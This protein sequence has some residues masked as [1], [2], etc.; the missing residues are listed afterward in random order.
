MRALVGFV[1]WTMRIVRQ[2]QS[3]SLGQYPQ[4]LDA[5][6]NSSHKTVHI[7]IRPQPLTMSAVCWRLGLH[8]SINIILVHGVWRMLGAGLFGMFSHPTCFILAYYPPKSF[9]LSYISA[10]IPLFGMWAAAV[11]PEALLSSALRSSA[12]WPWS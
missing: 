9:A 11:H 2:T 4:V 8:P 6:S 3:G 10:H 7:S 1:D 5:M 12:S